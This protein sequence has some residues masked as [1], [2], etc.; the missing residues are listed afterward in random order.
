MSELLLYSGAV[1][2]TVVFV[3]F[4]KS[5]IS[6]WKAGPIC[7]AKESYTPLG[8]ILFYVS[9]AI[10]VAGIYLTKTHSS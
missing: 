2:M 6:F 3:F 7:K 5:G 9:I 4:R 1:L 8:V 10:G